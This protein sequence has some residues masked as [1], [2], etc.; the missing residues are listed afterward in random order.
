MNTYTCL[1]RGVCLSSRRFLTGV[2]L[3]G[4]FCPGLF[5]SIPLLSEYIHYTR[6]LN[7]TFNFRF[8]MYEMFFKCEITCSW[9]LSSVTPSRTPPLE[10]DVLYGRPS[11]SAYIAFRTRPLAISFN[12]NT[13]TK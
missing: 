9:T 3:S 10:R 4:R 12:L 5:L 11:W 7:I 13:P 1:Y 6:K 2:F 8:P